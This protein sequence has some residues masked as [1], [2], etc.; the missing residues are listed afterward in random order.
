VLT[1]N[2][3][4][5]AEEGQMLL[6]GVKQD[7]AWLTSRWELTYPAGW[8]GILNALSS[9]YEYYG[10]LEILVD[11]HLV[12]IFNK[13]DIMKIEEAANITFRGKSTIIG[14]PISITMYNQV[15]DVDVDVSMSSVEFNK[16]DYKSFNLSMCQYLDSIELS[17][18]R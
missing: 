16:A 13:R 14:V 11:N 6:I 3:R 17:M 7:G 1:L 4:V 9:V 18:Y 10:S 5:N 2:I 12:E 15:K 8:N